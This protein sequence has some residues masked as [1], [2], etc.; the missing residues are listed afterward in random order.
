[1]GE[2]TKRMFHAS[3]TFSQ[4]WEIETQQSQLVFPLRKF[5]Y[6]SV[7]FFWNKNENNKWC[8]NQTSFKP[9]ER[10]WSLILKMESHVSFGDLKIKV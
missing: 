7:K 3:N 9:F 8:I 1:M 4:V 6:Y 5:E 2:S 10:Y